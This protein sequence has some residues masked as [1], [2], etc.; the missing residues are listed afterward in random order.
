[1]LGFVQKVLIA[2][3]VAPLVEQVFALSDPSFI[4]SWI[5]ALAYTIQL[6]FDFMGYSGMA[7]GLGL[8]MGFRFI[9]NFNH[10]YISRSITEFWRRWHISL[11]SWLKDYLYIPL[12]GNRKGA[13]RTYINLL[14][15]MLLGG[16]WHGANWTFVLWGAWHGAILA[17][18]RRLG[19]KAAQWSKIMIVP[20]LLAVIVSW[21]M[22]RAETVG[23]ALEMYRGMLGLNG[24]AM[25]DIFQW[26]VELSSF[27][28]SCDW[29]G[30]RFCASQVFRISG[31]Y[32]RLKRHANP[33]L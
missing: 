18:E 23:Q 30:C 1:M 24:M 28:I 29:L 3:S 25:G 12:G 33:W 22:F 11:S 5:G 7:I 31:G 21:V 20:T 16:A 2:D 6:Y 15:T 26:Q 32:R 17:G 19:L 13:K 27:D 8:M 10:P 14:L 4:E 9:E